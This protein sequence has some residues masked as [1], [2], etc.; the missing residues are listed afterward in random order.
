M[1]DIISDE[2]TF[3]DSPETSQMDETR[4]T[5]MTIVAVQDQIPISFHDVDSAE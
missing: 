4:T 3:D 5:G 2:E 1:I